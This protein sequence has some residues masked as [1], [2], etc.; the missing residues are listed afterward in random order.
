MSKFYGIIGY[1]VLDESI[2]SVWTP[3]IVERQVAGELIKNHHRLENG[4]GVNDDVT[5]SNDLSILA[6]PYARDH[7]QNMRYILWHGQRWKIIGVSVEWPRLKLTI[8]GVWNG[9]A[10]ES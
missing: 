5:F 9:S 2:P 7:F 6:D 4:V 10:P 1:E 3:T 8:G